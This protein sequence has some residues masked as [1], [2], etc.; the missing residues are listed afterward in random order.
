MVKRKS[1]EEIHAGLKGVLDTLSEDVVKALDIKEE[2]RVLEKKVRQLRDQEIQVREV[3]DHLKKTRDKMQVELKKKEKQ[4]EDLQSKIN[5][6]KED[7]AALQSEKLVLGQ[8]IKSLQREK[9]M[10]Q[11]SLEKTNDMLISLKHQI[12]EFDEEIRA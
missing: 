3:V 11:K 12:T 1:V 4:E 6:M 7:R 8:Q 5:A 2:R 9:E 10:M